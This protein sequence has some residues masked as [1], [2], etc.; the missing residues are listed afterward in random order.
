MEVSLAFLVDILKAGGPYVVAAI[1]ISSWLSERQERRG[2]E[3]QLVNIYEETLALVQETTRINEK[4]QQ[5][6]IALKEAVQ[7]LNGRLR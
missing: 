2:K 5:A 3:R 7:A 4:M 1:F 6:L